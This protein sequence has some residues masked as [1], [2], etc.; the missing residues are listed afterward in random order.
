MWRCPSGLGIWKLGWAPSNKRSSAGIERQTRKRSGGARRYCVRSYLRHPRRTHDKV[1]SPPAFGGHACSVVA[2][3]CKRRIEA[4]FRWVLRCSG[5]LGSKTRLEGKS[6]GGS[7]SE[8]EPASDADH[9]CRQSIR[10]LSWD[11]RR[12]QPKHLLA[13]RARYYDLSVTNGQQEKA[14]NHLRVRVE[15]WKQGF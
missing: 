8:R 14:D 11:A 15:A 12:I 6:C 9:R 5:L 2:S 1:H 4:A 13:Y 7:S 10:S 3:L